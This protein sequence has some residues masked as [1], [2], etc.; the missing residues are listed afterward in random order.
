MTSF[1][2][3]TGYDFPPIRL[4]MNTR[5]TISIKAYLNRRKLSTCIKLAKNQYV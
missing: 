1:E 4:H 3:L 5:M 2:Y